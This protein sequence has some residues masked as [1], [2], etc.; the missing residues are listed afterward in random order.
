MAWFNWYMKRMKLTRDLQDTGP[1]R[2][3]L[4]YQ[5][6]QRRRVCLCACVYMRERKGDTTLYPM[7]QFSSVAQSCLTLCDPMN[8]STPGLPVPHLPSIIQSSIY[9]LWF[10]CQVMSDSCNTMDCS[11]SGSSV[12]WISQARILEWVAIVCA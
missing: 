7:L 8:R 12:H 4:E 5:D 10:S 11:P 2:G 9:L 6:K 3:G 1:V